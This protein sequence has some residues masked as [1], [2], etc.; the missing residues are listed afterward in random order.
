MSGG[1]GGDTYAFARGDGRDLVLLAGASGSGDADVLS[2]GAG[3]SAP[4]MRLSLAGRDLVVAF[5]GAPGDGVTIE[6]FVLAGVRLR[7][8][9]ADGTSLGF[10]E[11]LGRITGATAG[12]D[13]LTGVVDPADRS[14]ALTYGGRGDD[15]LA[16]ARQ[17]AA[18]TDSIVLAKGDGSDRILDT[19]DAV[20][21]ADELVLVGGI[22][23]SGVRL[24]RGGPDG[25]NL[26]LTF[27]GG[28]ADRI[29][30]EGQFR[31]AVGRGLDAV[32]FEDGTVRGRARIQA[33]LLSQQATAG[34]DSILGFAGDDTLAGGAGGN[35]YRFGRGDGHDTIVDRASGNVYLL[36]QPFG[37]PD[38]YADRLEFGAGVRPEDVGVAR[39][40]ADPDDVVLTLSAGD[41]V[42]L[43][44]QLAFEPSGV[45]AVAFADGTVWTRSALA[46]RIVDA[47]ATAG[48]DTVEGFSTP[49]VVPDYMGPRLGSGLADTLAGGGGD[50]LLRGGGGGDTYAFARGD[51]RDT[52]AAGLAGAAGGE[53]DRI[54]FGAGVAPDD[55]DL[56]RS[57]DDLMVALRGTADAVTVREGVGVGAGGGRPP[58]PARGDAGPGL[59][60]RRAGRRLRRPGRARRRLR[61]VGD[62]GR[63][64]AAPGLAALRRRDAN[65]L[66]AAGGRRRGALPVRLTATDAA[67]DAGSVVFAIEVRDANDAPVA[68]AAPAPVPAAPGARF[69]YQIPAGL[70][71]DPDDA[72]PGAAPTALSYSVARGDGSPLPAWL[73][74]DAATWTLSGTPSA[75]DQGPLDLLLR[76]TDGA[77]A[78]GAVHLG[79]RVGAANAAPAA[80]AP[81]A[82]QAATEDR[83]FSFAVPAGAFAAADPG[84]RLVLSAA[85]ADGSP[86][87]AWLSFDPETRTLSGTPGNADIGAVSI[88]LTARDIHGAAASTAFAVAVA[89]AND[90]PVASGAAAAGP[91]AATEDRAFSFALPVGLFTDLDAGDALVLTARLGDGSPLPAWLRFDGRAFSGAPGERDTGVLELVVEAADRAGA[92]AQARLFLVVAGANDAPVVLAPPAP[93][94]VE[95]GAPFAW[96]LPAGIFADPDGGGG[97]DVTARMADGTAFPSWLLYGPLARTFSGTPS[98]WSVEDREGSRPYRVELTGTDRDGASATAFLDIVVRT[99]FEG[100]AVDGTP[101]ADALAGTAGPDTLRGGAGDDLVGGGFGDD[102]VRFGLGDGRDTVAADPGADALRFGA[103]IGAADL[104]FAFDPADDPYAGNLTVGIAGT[105]DSVKVL[106]QYRI[107][108]GRS[109]GFGRF[110]FADGTALTRQQ[111]DR[112]VAAGRG[113]IEGTAGRDAI[114]GTPLGDRIVGLAGDDDLRGYLGDDT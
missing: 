10:S 11:I 26:V 13:A 100:A 86:L 110:E 80:G 6:D 113:P 29:E 47:Q 15:T 61:A 25:A 79:V 3:L 22:A 19:A 94:A 74:F 63:R 99:P 58:R 71:A 101:A 81:V 72:H 12:A 103:G 39:G 78:T 114:P 109:Q 97:V 33:E 85:L 83:P 102:V 40:G 34:A 23:P 52:I 51:W 55:L 107:E 77:G 7:M 54:A 96:T 69:S 17:G 1:A 108:G 93:H 21:G 16:S 18:G 42:T 98:H 106:G 30:V 50:D 112:L 46:Q 92:T 84:D 89:N 44:D 28:G 87:P 20:E 56:S 59:L 14:T 57:G 91:Y 2:F 8:G 9:F 37:N 38:P 65:L 88:R 5:D 64:L 62:A 104:R 111:F 48:A 75:A 95:R 66:G 49:V 67:G 53:A 45:E 43:R 76:A 73:S 32:R 27:A 35:T 60:L 31:D 36:G 105:A 70:F 82:A 90:A 41:S 4:G 68:A 24:A